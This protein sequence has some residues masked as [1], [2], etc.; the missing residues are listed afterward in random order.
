MIRASFAALSLAALAFTTPVSP[1]EFSAAVV[2][3]MGG[4]FDKSFNEAA[5]HGA[6]RFKKETGISYREFEVTQ[7]AQRDQGLRNMARRG[8][9]MIIA[10]GFAQATPLEK[11]AKE[12]K[13][14]RF[15]IIDAVVDLP[16]V[17]SVVFKEHEGSFLVGMAAA[18]A[19]KTG[20][21][22]F[23]GG[24]DIPLIRKF[25]LG[26]VEG[27]KYVNP[28]AEVFQNMTGTTPAAWNDPTKGGELARSQFDRGADVIYAAAGGT[29]IGVLQAAKDN[30][31]LAIGVDSNQNHLQPGF[32]LTSMIK[33]VDVAVYEAFKSAKDNKW[34][35]GVK[36]LGL[37]ED[38][39]G[40]SMDEHNKALITAD[41]KAKLDAA[42]ADIIAGKI[43]V[44]DYMAKK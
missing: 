7:E 23:I 21:V 6:E 31:K 18:M 22:G 36:V 27:A 43:K 33:R 3:D 15:T 41:M 30:K 28:A 42:R 38:G 44:T 32:V 13:H 29:G 16:N 1:A 25:A 24:M 34:K 9:N 14:A 5:Y 10:I 37:K 8:A 20:K 2:F 4:K 40:Y 11:V 39:V 17:Q 19:S 26:Y 35:G 12:Y